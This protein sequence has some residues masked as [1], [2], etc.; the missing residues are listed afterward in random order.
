MQQGTG[1]GGGA[2]GQALA[3]KCWGLLGAILKPAERRSGAG[4]CEGAGNRQALSARPC[5][6]AAGKE[7]PG[8]L[9]RAS[10]GLGDGISAAAWP[11][12]LP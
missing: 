2:G 7:K 8:G 4:G 6:C 5:G 1:S 9:G 10:L 12:A 11:L 3:A